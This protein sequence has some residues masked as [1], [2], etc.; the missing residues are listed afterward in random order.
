[1]KGADSSLSGS[2]GSFFDRFLKGSLHDGL[3]L[4]LL[5]CR[6][7]PVFGHLPVEQLLNLPL[8]LLELLLDGGRCGCGVHVLAAI[9]VWRW[10]AWKACHVLPSFRNSLN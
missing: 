5:R 1:M 8:Q 3:H 7:K 6:Q 4:C 10:S 2:R 9:L